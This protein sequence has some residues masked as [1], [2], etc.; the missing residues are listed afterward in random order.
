MTDIDPIAR[1]YFTTDK[2]ILRTCSIK[3]FAAGYISKPEISGFSFESNNDVAD[4]Q[5]L[6]YY[7]PATDDYFIQE[8]VY[9]TDQPISQELHA[10]I[11]EFDS[12]GSTLDRIYLMMIPEENTDSLVVANE[13]WTLLDAENR[14][15]QCSAST[16]VNTM[17][18]QNQLKQSKQN[19]VHMFVNNGQL[20]SYEETMNVQNLAWGFSMPYFTEEQLALYNQSLDTGIWVNS[21]IFE[22]H[23]D[24]KITYT[25]QDDID[26]NAY[27]KW[28]IAYI[29]GLAYSSYNVF[30]FS[31]GTVHEN[32]WFLD[33]NIRVY[34][35]RDLAYYQDIYF[36]SNSKYA[37]TKD[38]V[39]DVLEAEVNEYGLF[40]VSV[41]EGGIDI[42]SKIESDTS[43][44]NCI[45][46]S[47][48]TQAQLASY[49]PKDTTPTGD[50]IYASGISEFE[51][52]TLY[53]TPLTDDWEVEFDKK[54]PD[55]AYLYSYD[56]DGNMIQ[57]LERHVTEADFTVGPETTEVFSPEEYQENT[58]AN[59]GNAYYFNV[60][61]YSSSYGGSSDKQG[62]MT[63]FAENIHHYDHYFSNPDVTMD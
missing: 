30:Q 50:G 55:L 4:F 57:K 19:L 34:E 13:N 36:F 8:F 29:D 63:Y 40:L 44:I 35:N 23:Y 18:V 60:Q 10:I 25:I 15:Y 2:E 17:G 42:T 39:K 54:Y 11:L 43:Y 49:V 41:E 16:Y 62:R 27:Q 38:E 9:I 46:V 3:N 14:V 52:D 20:N 5:L 7:T 12:D 59:V 47:Y 26:P 45:Q 1:Q 56:V 22:N 33:G 37:L 51:G 58:Y 61:I 32:T 48:P 31:G 21:L 6:D 24:D 53:F 28:V